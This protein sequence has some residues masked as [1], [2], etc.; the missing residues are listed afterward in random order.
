MSLFFYGLIKLAMILTK[1]CGSALRNGV[2]VVGRAG[3]ALHAVCLGLLARLRAT[4]TLSAFRGQFWDAVVKKGSIKL[5]NRSIVSE[6][7]GERC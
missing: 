2:S 6:E 3:L 1:V 5:A 7:E 4:G